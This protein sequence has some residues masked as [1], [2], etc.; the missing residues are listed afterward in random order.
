MNGNAPCLGVVIP[1]WNAKEDLS[2]TLDH[3][4]RL[5]DR[6]KSNMEIVISDGA[7]TD[8]TLEV[9]ASF[10]DLIGHVDPDMAAHCQRG[11]VW[12]VLSH[13]MNKEEPGAFEIIQAALNAKNAMGLI[14]HEMEHLNGLA[15]VIIDSGA[16]MADDFNWRLIR[17]RVMHTK[18]T[19]V[20]EC[21]EFPMLCQM[22]CPKSENS[23]SMALHSASPLTPHVSAT[24]CASVN[25]MRRCPSRMTSFF[26]SA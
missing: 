13:K 11:L 12:E 2:F 10:M 26:A 3:F 22:I 8:G 7:S 18:N 19:A 23:C 9:A 1:T 14:E 6:I 5:P 20:S 21:P 24:S 4:A 16:G 17:D 25:V 15:T